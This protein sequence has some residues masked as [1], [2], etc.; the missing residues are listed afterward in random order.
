MPKIRLNLPYMAKGKINSRQKGKRGE[1][2]VAKLLSAWWGAEF[3]STPLSGGFSTKTFR[4]DWNAAGDIVTPDHSF[5]FTVEV[6]N[7]EGWHLE[8]LLTSDKCLFYSWWKQAVDETL[9]GK[10]TL[11]VFTRNRQ[12]W[13]VCMTDVARWDYVEH[14]GDI[15]LKRNGFLLVSNDEEGNPRDLYITLFENLLK[16]DPEFWKELYNPNDDRD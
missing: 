15:H 13:Y 4:N 5:P 14:S 2:E 1:R 7:C 6:K 3:T 12:P 10:K 9:P 8:Q 11:L 16:T